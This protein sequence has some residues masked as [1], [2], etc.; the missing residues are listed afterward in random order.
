[1]EQVLADV[2]EFKHDWN[3]KKQER[4]PLIGVE[5]QGMDNFDMFMSGVGEPG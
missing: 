1:M 2:K 5:L 3:R 4:H